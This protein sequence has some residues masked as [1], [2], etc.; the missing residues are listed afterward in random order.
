MSRPYFENEIQLWFPKE[1]FT[2]SDGSP[3]Y[4]RNVRYEKVRQEALNLALAINANVPDSAE[5]VQLFSD[6]RRC[7]W[8]AR[9]AI[10]LG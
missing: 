2:N 1:L 3:D 9:D 5:K 8:A 10:R 4:R 7:T 6:L